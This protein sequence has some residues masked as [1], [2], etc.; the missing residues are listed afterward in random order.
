VTSETT[1]DNN[2]PVV[3]L[4]YTFTNGD[5]NGLQSEA[6]AY[7]DKASEQ[8]DYFQFSQLLADRRPLDRMCPPG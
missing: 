5:L 1:Q 3:T 2:N 8:G 6:F 7:N 4:N